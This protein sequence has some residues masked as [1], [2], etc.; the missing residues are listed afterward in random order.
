MNQTI[1]KVLDFFYPNV[2]PRCGIILHPEETVCDACAEKM[3][4]SQNDY[5]QKCGKTNCMCQYRKLA[6][7]RAVVA[8]R[9][10]KESAPAVLALKESKNTNFAYFT[11]RI[12]AERLRHGSYYQ[13][14]ETDYVMPVPMHKA[15]QKQRGYNQ[16]GLIAR[17]LAELLHLP[18][19]EDVLYK[20]KSA[21]E[22]HT[23]T[24]AQE[25]AKNVG[26]FGIREVSLENMRIILCDDVLT[27]G[28][29]MNRCAELLKFK[30]AAFVTAAAASS[31]SPPE[32]KETT[33]HKEESLL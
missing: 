33:K 22:Q 6:Y 19:R 26:S 5:C 10:D 15:K 32:Q 8:C 25:R 14:Q 20:E 9:Y 16:A 29:T 12:L 24:S 23:L 18:Y 7:D 31:T 3:L 11:A 30:G 17:E 2:C 27:T 21:A 1:R 28:S 13:V 4:L